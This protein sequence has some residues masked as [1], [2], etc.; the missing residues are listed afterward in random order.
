MCKVLAV[1]GIKPE[2][3][4]KKLWTFL[5]AATTFM[6]AYDKDGVGYVAQSKEYGLC[7]EKLL[8]P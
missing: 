7:G 3:A 6:S 1:A 2:V 5:I 8:K 4:A